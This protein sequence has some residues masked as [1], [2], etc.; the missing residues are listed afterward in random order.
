MP[1][2][3][4][5][6][7]WTTTIFTSVTDNHIRWLRQIPL[8]TIYTWSNLGFKMKSSKIRAIQRQSQSKFLF[9]YHKSF[10]ISA[11][12]CGFFIKLCFSQ[13]FHS[14]STPG[15]PLGGCLPTIPTHT[16]P[17]LRFLPQLVFTEL[18]WHWHPLL[19]IRTSVHH[20]YNIYHRER[21]RQ[22]VSLHCW[23]L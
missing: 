5:I 6:L 3:Y 2:I 9:S 12:A 1:E 18:A 20:Y 8:S 13:N 17:S 10:T 14:A 22:P 19:C 23:V 16:P 15:R 11:P 7:Y 21:E 4:T